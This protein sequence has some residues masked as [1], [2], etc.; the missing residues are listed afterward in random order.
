MKPFNCPNCNTQMK[1]NKQDMDFESEI[2][3]K[4]ICPECPLIV[5][6]WRSQK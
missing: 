1:L 5:M 2:Y 6:D 3:D 4:W